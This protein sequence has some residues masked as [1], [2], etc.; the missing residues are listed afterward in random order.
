MNILAT[1]A[2]RQKYPSRSLILFSVVKIETVFGSGQQA[3]RQPKQVLL[4]VL[5]A[6]L[7][8]NKREKSLSKRS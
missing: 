7:G 8:F 2:R 5:K 1:G 6:L 4:L 3:A